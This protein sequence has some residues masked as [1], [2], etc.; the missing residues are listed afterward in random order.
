MSKE[1]LVQFSKQEVPIY[2]WAICCFGAILLGLIVGSDMRLAI[3][4]ILGLALALPLGWLFFR[5]IEIGFVLTLLAIIP[6]QLIRFSLGTD[7]RGGSAILISDLLL[8]LAVLVWGVRKMT[9]DQYIPRSKVIGPLMLFLGVA[10]LSLIFGA[11]QIVDFVPDAPGK[12]MIIAIMYWARLLLYSMFFL[13]ALDALKS[14]K[15]I[16]RLLHLLILIGFILSIGG[17]IQLWLMPDFTSMAVAAGWDPHQGRLLST[18]FDPNFMGTFLAMDMVI[19]I[20]MALDSSRKLKYK[21]WIV[22]LGLIISL[23]FLLTYSR[24][25]LLGF[26]VAFLVIGLLKAPKLLAIGVLAMALAIG[27]MPRLAQ[28]LTE[29][30]SIDET[31][32]KRLESW[33]KGIRIA[34]SNPITGT[35]YNTLGTVQDGLGLVDEFDVNNRGGIENSIITV[36]VTMGIAG[37]L[38]Y[39]YLLMTMLIMTFRTFYRRKYS[40]SLRHL[41][42]GVGAALIVVIFASTTLN[43]LFYPAIMLQI[44][45]L[46]AA[47]ERGREIEETENK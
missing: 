30:I 21:S 20:A 34:I 24:G 28:R 23:A 11:F 39:L 45:A 5:Y 26:M 31:G 10:F 1:S 15:S 9:V 14:I 4:A 32:I 18:F 46:M 47:V 40:Q 8:A 13:V 29:G 36:F 37:L 41:G 25:A 44:W 12:P 35:G 2:V 42:L 22:F 17:F 7:A 19:I 27:S 3:L 33:D 16:E 43:A 6:G 38:A